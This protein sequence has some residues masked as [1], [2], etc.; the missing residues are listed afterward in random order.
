M[1]KVRWY[2]TLRVLTSLS[3]AVLVAGGALIGGL[4]VALTPAIAT[5]PAS[6]QPWVIGPLIGALVLLI[7]HAFAE[8]KKRTYDPLLVFH[9]DEQFSCQEMR[10]KRAAASNLLKAHRGNLRQHA[11][12]FA[13]IDDVLDFFEDLG[14]YEHGYQISPEVLHHAFYHWIR[15]YYTIAKDY[16][17]ASQNKESTQWEHIKELYEL[18]S[19]VEK[20][21]LRVRQVSVLTEDDIEEFLE[22]E[23]QIDSREVIPCP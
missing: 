14:F 15:G 10:K 21:K 11:R 18:T 9:F 6:L 5:S 12:E 3:V 13:D 17:E 2:C 4:V 23:I 1:G 7:A 19:A 20:R 8:Y 16:I 22:D